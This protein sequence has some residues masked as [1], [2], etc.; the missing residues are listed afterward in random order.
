MQ[1]VVG[2]KEKEAIVIVSRPVKWG[3]GGLTELEPIRIRR[4]VMT[5]IYENLGGAFIVQNSITRWCVRT[6][7]AGMDYGGIKEE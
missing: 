2:Y 4:K 6:G 5:P 3:K 7:L 1:R